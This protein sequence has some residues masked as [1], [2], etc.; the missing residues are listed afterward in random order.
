[1]AVGPNVAKD[2]IQH[3]LSSGQAF[4]TD[5]VE[6]D[7]RE[8][9]FY[10]DILQVDVQGVAVAGCRQ[11]VYLEVLLLMVYFE[12]LMPSRLSV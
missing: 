5:G 6:I 1:M 8:Y 10:I 4:E 2:A 9:V 7:Q 3:C 12:S 11:T